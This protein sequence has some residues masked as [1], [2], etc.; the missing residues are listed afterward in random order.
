M[1]KY[2]TT[3]TEI[4]RVDS[5]AEVQFLVEEAKKDLMYSLVKYNREF[6]QRKSKGE[7]IDEWYKVTLVK[8]FNDEKEPEDVVDVSYS[9]GE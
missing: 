4:Y 9:K 3:V 8:G 7:V 5:E 1:S 6:K 2:L